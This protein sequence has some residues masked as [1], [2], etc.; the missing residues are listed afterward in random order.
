MLYKCSWRSYCVHFFWIGLVDQVGLHTKGTTLNLSALP[1]AIG[2]YGFCYS[3]H[4]VFPNIYTSMEKRSL[5]PAV[6]LASFGICTLMYAG[7]AGM[8][9][10]MFGETTQSQFTHNMPKDLVASKIVVWTTVVNP[11]TK[12][13][14]S[15]ST[16]IICLLVAL[17]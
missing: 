13:P 6:L 1:V 9:Y 15:V 2:L 16:A 10:T 4:A 8:G 3:G 5:F 7:V 14:F 12:Y 17:S 11:F